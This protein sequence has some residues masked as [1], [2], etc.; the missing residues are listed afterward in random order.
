MSQPGQTEPIV[1]LSAARADPGQELTVTAFD[2]T[3]GLGPGIAWY[4]TVESNGEPGLEANLH[5][6]GV[7]GDAQSGDGVFTAL[8]A[9]PM[10]TGSYDLQL[11]EIRASG[12]S[13]VVSRSLEVVRRGDLW[14]D[15]ST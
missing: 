9:A 13:A 6:D 3:I 1:T 10:E 2:P 4:A 14:I 11:R 7:G 12:A 5:D 8:F 15:S